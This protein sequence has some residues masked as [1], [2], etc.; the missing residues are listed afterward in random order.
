VDLSVVIPARDVAST[1]AAQLDALRAQDW[2]GEWEIVVVDNKSVDRTASIVREHAEHDPRVRLVA[3]AERDGLCYARATGVEAAAADRIAICDGD[4][5]VAAG[6][7]RAMAEGL[8]EHRVVTGPLEV[9]RLN[10]AWLADTRGRPSP[11]RCA[12]WFGLFPLVS[13]G[14]LGLWREVWQ[15]VGP[16]DERFL[17]AED[18]EWSLRLFLADVHVHFAAGAVVHYRYRDSARVLWRQGNTYGFTRPQLRRR[19]VDAGLPPPSRVAGWRSWAWLVAHL[20]GLARA[21]G[22]ARWSWV[23]GVRVGHLRGSARARTVFL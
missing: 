17:G 16:F 18:A 7:L 1:L 20:P 6:W 10:P 11:T 15:A 23:A 8:H 3:A 19:V 22:R 2:D 9:D 5:V 13:G 21:T 14:N 12:S 4:D